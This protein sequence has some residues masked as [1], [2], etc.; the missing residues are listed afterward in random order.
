MSG[1]GTA[2]TLFDR[3]CD[4]IV[5][6][7]SNMPMNRTG[8]SKRWDCTQRN[9]SYVIGHAKRTYGVKVTSVVDE[10]RI[11]GYHLS[12]A[13]VLDPVAV[14]ARHRRRRRKAKQ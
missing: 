1:R 7:G 3:V 4:L 8:L 10:A 13:G 12:S 5:V 6:A 11:S 2:D 9:V 14:A